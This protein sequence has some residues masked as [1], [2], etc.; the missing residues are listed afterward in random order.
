MPELPHRYKTEHF[1]V[2]LSIAYFTDSD[3]DAGATCLQNGSFVPKVEQS[4][5]E[6]SQGIYRLVSCPAG[7]QLVNSTGEGIFSQENQFCKACSLGQYI[8]D[9]NRDIC[10]GCPKGTEPI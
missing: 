2:Q 4:V 10:Q 1:N 3:L 9:P 6:V 5:W 8:I 7:H